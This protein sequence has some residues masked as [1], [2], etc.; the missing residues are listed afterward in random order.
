[1]ILMSSM[2]LQQYEI[3]IFYFQLAEIIL[4]STMILL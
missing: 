1:M 2:I 4:T 3:I